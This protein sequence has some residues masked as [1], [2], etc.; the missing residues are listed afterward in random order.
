MAADLCSD[1]FTTEGEYS[2]IP[3]EFLRVEKF[4]DS[5]NIKNI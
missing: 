5:L 3:G 2:S 4:T 1:P